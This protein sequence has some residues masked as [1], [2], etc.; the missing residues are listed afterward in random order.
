M[1]KETLYF[2]IVAIISG[3][4]CNPMSHGPYNFKQIHVL[5]YLEKDMS[6]K[7]DKVW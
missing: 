7:Y 1:L 6:L 3:L 2:N 5:V 4:F